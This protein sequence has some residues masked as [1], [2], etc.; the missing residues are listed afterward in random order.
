MD[1]RILLTSVQI[2]VEKDPRNTHSPYKTAMG[3]PLYIA[4][5]M[6]PPVAAHALSI[7]SQSGIHFHNGQNYSLCNY[8]T[9]AGQTEEVEV[10]AKLLFVAQCCL[11]L[12][13]IRID[14]CVAAVPAAL[15]ALDAGGLHVLSCLK[16][17]EDGSEEGKA[18][19]E[20]RRRDSEAES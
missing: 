18:N 14:T 13:G 12:D 11:E 2:T 1:T 6:V 10:S 17:R 5:T 15:V 3:P 9:Q 8:E 19:W 7:F 20:E 4:V 16:R